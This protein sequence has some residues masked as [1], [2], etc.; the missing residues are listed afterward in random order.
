MDNIIP[1]THNQTELETENG[2]LSKLQE[3]RFADASDETATG[4]A[5]D[6]RQRA[7]AGTAGLILM[8]AVGALFD[9]LQIA[10]NFFLIGPFVNW[11]VS[12][13][14]G[15]VFLLWTSSRKKQR[16]G[17]VGGFGWL[18]G[19]FAIELIPGFDLLPVWTAFAVRYAM[20]EKTKQAVD[21]YA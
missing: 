8:V 15:A 18:I 16:G 3:E 10:L 13:I 21:T 2:R 1:A 7:E 12:L 19:S 11:L 4:E 20:E 5:A 17:G 14:A 6:G 9:V